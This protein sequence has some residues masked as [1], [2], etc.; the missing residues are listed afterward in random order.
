MAS[1][2][3]PSPA[4]KRPFKPAMP[5]MWQAAHLE[6]KVKNMGIKNLGKQRKGKRG[7]R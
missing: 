1:T 5:A 2:K 7:D 4:P 6:G 3:K